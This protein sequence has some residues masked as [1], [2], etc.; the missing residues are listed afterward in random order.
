[1]VPPGVASRRQ[2]NPTI[3]RGQKRSSIALSSRPMVLTSA[4]LLRLLSL[5][6][7]RRFWSGDELAAEL[8][9][10]ARSVRRDVDR[11][12]SLGYPVHAEGGVGGGYQLGAGRDL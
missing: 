1:M 4:R 7:S 2:E 11:L 3:H 10:T 5:L 8:S 6:Q 12:R 9:I